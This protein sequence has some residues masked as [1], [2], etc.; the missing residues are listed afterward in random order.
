MLATA[1]NVDQE[2]EGGAKERAV[3]A[4][5]ATPEEE[6][7]SQELEEEEG[8]DGA[9]AVLRPRGMSS[10]DLLLAG[11]V[12]RRFLS[13]SLCVYVCVLRVFVC[14]CRSPHHLQKQRGM[15]FFVP[16][17]ERATNVPP[18]WCSWRLLLRHR[19]LFFL[20]LLC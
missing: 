12:P 5:L 1:A 17:A 3:A 15:C 8:Q 19:R 13:L 14:L 9:N 16:C 2:G 6:E 10:V 4:A 7:V 20:L 18:G 11:E